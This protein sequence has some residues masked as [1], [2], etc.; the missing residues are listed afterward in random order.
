MK[1]TYNLILSFTRTGKRAEFSQS[2]L[3]AYLSCSRPVANR[4]VTALKA[5]G[6]VAADPDN[7]GRGDVDLLEALPIVV[8]FAKSAEVKRVNNRKSKGIKMLQAVQLE[9]VNLSCMLSK[10]K[11]NLTMLTATTLGILSSMML[12]IQNSPMLCLL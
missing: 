1:M 9:K 4:A 2:Y 3:A 12:L 6:L 10:T 11:N 8:E 5:L 7:R